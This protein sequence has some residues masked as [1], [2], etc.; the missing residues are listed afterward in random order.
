MF[1]KRSTTIRDSLAIG[2][3][4]G[5]T[6]HQDDGLA[7]VIILIYFVSLALGFWYGW[8]WSK[9]SRSRSA[10]EDEVQLLNIFVRGTLNG[11]CKR[12]ARVEAKLDAIGEQQAELIDGFQRQPKTEIR[13]DPYQLE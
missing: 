10:L 12:L 1:S 5:V 8:Y 7:G 3:H 13:I 6:M 11:M 4:W 2:G 9:H